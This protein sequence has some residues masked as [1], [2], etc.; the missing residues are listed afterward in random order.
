MSKTWLITGTSGGFGRAMA[1]KPL[2]LSDRGCGHY[3]VVRLPGSLGRNRF[4]AMQESLH[5]ALALASP[6]MLN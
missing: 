3:A 4:S 1:K 5:S 2:A 6:H